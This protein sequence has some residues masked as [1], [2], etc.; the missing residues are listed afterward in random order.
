MVKLILE[1]KEAKEFL[2][3]LYN[4]KA[5]L[6]GAVKKETDNLKKIRYENTLK[7]INPIITK[8][9]GTLEESEKPETEFKRYIVFCNKCKLRTRVLA[10]TENEVKTYWMC[11]CGSQNFS[12][13]GEEE[14]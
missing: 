6:E 1:D 3:F 4:Q 7:L 10:K 9:E 14:T 2:T 5:W 13:L 12:I 8:L 11:G